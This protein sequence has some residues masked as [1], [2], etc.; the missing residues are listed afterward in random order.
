M[1][2]FRQIREATKKKM[3]PGEHVYDSKVN[4]HH[5]MVHK[6]NNKFVAYID[7]EKLNTYNTLNDAKNAATQFI[8][9]AGDK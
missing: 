6:V 9:M 8:K 4:K 1:R 2:S 5:V 3:P 7:M